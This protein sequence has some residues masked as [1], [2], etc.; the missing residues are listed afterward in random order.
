LHEMDGRDILP[1]SGLTL[2][3]ATDP[4]QHVICEWSQSAVVVNSKLY[5]GQP[6]LNRI[7]VFHT[8]QLT[9]VQVIATDPQPKKLWTIQATSD[10]QQIWVLCDGD[11]INTPDSSGSQH[12]R[13]SLREFEES[14]RD[15]DIEFQ[16]SK[17]SSSSAQQQRQ[18]NNRKTIQVI[19]LMPNN[20]HAPNVIHLQPIDGHFDLVYDMFMP[21]YSP[22]RL[23][24]QHSITNRYAH[25][26]HWD[27]R[28]LIKI[29]MTQFKYVKTINLADCSPI[30]GIYTDHGLLILQCQTP[31]TH[32][33]T[34]QIIVDQ[35]TDA[36]VSYNTHVK[37]R[38]SYLSPNQQFLVN[39][40]H[41]ASN[42]A[43]TSIIV[44]R[45]TST[46]VEFLY[47]V[48]TSLDIVNCEFVWKSGNY[49]AV[50]A[51][52]TSNREDMLYLSLSDGRVELISGVGRPTSGSHRGMSMA[53][54]SRMLA[55]TA[56]ESVFVVD[57]N[58]N[59]IQ[60]ETV[61]RHQKP[62]T[63]IWT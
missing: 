27:E 55:V 26:S 40:L 63:L 56:T 57:L 47:D 12:G 30:N 39:V 10:E 42:L 16:W 28:E 46:G 18:I 6:N 54:K 59:R 19:R 23:H 52:G 49:D 48:R 61:Q 43:T 45:V 3:G 2:C 1:Q 37:A 31:V 15:E 51:S 58:T 33:L 8:L 24:Q 22:Q 50:L 41:N 17:Q 4:S 14:Q 7:V 32:Q 62:S 5:I 60:C 29:D 53:H 44:Q 38:N 11:Q 36:I 20:V 9:V 34:G 21:I 35:M 13:G 25:V